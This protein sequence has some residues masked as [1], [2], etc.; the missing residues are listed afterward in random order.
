MTIIDFMHAHWFLTWLLAWGVFGIA[1][2][3]VAATG[4]L[5]TRLFR[6][7]AVL[8]RGWPSAHLDADGDWKPAP[9]AS[10]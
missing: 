6:L 2:I 10:A 1:Y 8:A 7:I 3:V 9:K 4:G 5:I